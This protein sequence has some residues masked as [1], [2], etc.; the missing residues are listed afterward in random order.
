[1]TQEEFKQSRILNGPGLTAFTSGST[2]A[3][4]RIELPEQLLTESACR[5]NAFFG[6]TSASHLHVPL[7]FSYIA[8][9]MM[10]I[11][12]EVAGAHLTSE[13]PT[14]RPLSHPSLYGDARRIDLL[15]VVPSQMIHIL[16][17]T[18][19]GEPLPEIG[20]VIIGGSAIPDGLRERIAHSGINAYETY[21]MTE[22]ASHIAL[23]KVSDAET[24][25]FE[26]LEGITVS[27]TDDGRLVISM[28]GWR[29][30]VTNDI[31]ELS[32]NRHFRILGRADNVIVTGG[33]KLHPEEAERRL[34]T[35]WPELTFILRGEPD[36][37]WGQRI[38]AMIETASVQSIPSP[39]ILLAAAR[40]ALPAWALPKEIRLTDRLP[41]TPSGKLIRR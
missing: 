13:A 26:C 2:G 35:V 1:M 5:T 30:L 29:E 18:E 12:A 32:D 25:M 14:N 38:V 3:P 17:M 10:A 40:R 28:K 21:G 15:A 19:A 11:R 6:I 36:P 37:K 20:A 31:A 8:A 34:A 24:D 22:T 39:D 16:D 23:R 4:K 41:R 33:K 7:D 27:T 9:K